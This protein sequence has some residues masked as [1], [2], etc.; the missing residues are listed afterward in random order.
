MIACIHYAKNLKS[1]SAFA[2]GLEDNLRKSEFFVRDRIAILVV[3][4]LA[5][6]RPCASGDQ[7]AVSI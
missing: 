2:K 1:D 6:Q 7:S 4:S 3:Q 5:G